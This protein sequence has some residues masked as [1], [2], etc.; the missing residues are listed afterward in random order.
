ME[1]PQL[2]RPLN[3]RLD[4]NLVIKRLLNKIIGAPTHGLS[5]RLEIRQRGYRYAVVEAGDMSKPIV[6]KHGFEYLTTV[7]DYVLEQKEEE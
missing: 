1:S 7:W 5:G 4:I 2:Y 3:R 6:Q